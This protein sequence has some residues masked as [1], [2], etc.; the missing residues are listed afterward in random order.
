MMRRISGSTIAVLLAV[1]A[2]GAAQAATTYGVVCEAGSDFKQLIREG[3]GN[4]ELMLGVGS[5]AAWCPATRAVQVV[6]I[7]LE[8]EAFD[9][10]K[11]IAAIPATD[12][13]LVATKVE[14]TDADTPKGEATRSAIGWN[15]ERTFGQLRQQLKA[16]A[17]PTGDY[18][19][20]TGFR[21]YR[22]GQCSEPLIPLRYYITT[23]A[24][25]PAC[26]GGRL[27]QDGPTSQSFD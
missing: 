6:K 4:R 8:G 13:V 15:K 9:T 25:F 19:E 7:G 12:E 18:V 24:P 26:N 22:D 23:K 2:G 16:L 21:T 3:T 27:V 20:D 1:A 10:L 14:W 11:Q 5:I 17:Q